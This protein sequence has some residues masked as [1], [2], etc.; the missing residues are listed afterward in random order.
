MIV[1]T[2]HR[3]MWYLKFFFHGPGRVRT[4][5]FRFPN[6]SNR[7]IALIRLRFGVATCGSRASA[8]K[9]LL[10]DAFGP[11]NFVDYLAAPSAG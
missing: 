1:L 2:N 11:I 10:V 7:V 6:S 4:G 3:L 5:E 8:A 9:V